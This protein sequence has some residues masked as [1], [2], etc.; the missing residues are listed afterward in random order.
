MGTISEVD[1]GS[2]S[3]SSSTGETHCPEQHA[4]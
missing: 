4:L 3:D 1:N 2:G